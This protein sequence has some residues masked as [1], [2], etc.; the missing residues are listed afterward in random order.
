MNY[1]TEYIII[2]KYSNHN[3]LI[4]SENPNINQIEQSKTEELAKD[5]EFVK[6]VEAIVQEWAKQIEQVDFN[7]QGKYNFRRLRPIFIGRHIS[8]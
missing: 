8:T 2:I 5:A 3:K 1:V 6:E 4:D 7:S